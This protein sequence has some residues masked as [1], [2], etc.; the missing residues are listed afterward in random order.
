MIDQ[1][2][3]EIFQQNQNLTPE[4]LQ[5]PEVVKQIEAQ[6]QDK[7]DD[8]MTWREERELAGTRIL[9]YYTRKLD[10]KT[11]FNNGF[12]DALIAGEEIYCVDETN[13]EPVVRRCNPLMTYF[14]TN[15]HSHRVEDSNIIVEEQYLPLGE[16]LDRYHKYL[17]KAEIQELEDRN[18]NGGTR[19]SSKNNIINYGE[20]ISWKDSSDVDLFVGPNFNNASNDFNNYRVLRCVWRSIRLIKILHYLDENNEEQETEV[21]SSFKPDKSLGQWTEDMAIGEFWEG[22]KIANK[23]YVKVQPRSI[24]FRTLNNFSSCQSGY[25]GSIYNTNGQKVFSFMDKVKP[26]HLM[27]IT[28]AYRT[29]MAFMK[30]KGKIGL[31]D[32][33]LIPDGMNMDTWMYF[34]ETMGWAVIDSFKEGKKG[35]AMGKLAGMN[36]TRSDKIDLEMG[37]YIQQHIVAMQQIESRLEKI[38]GINDARKGTVPASAGLG[39]TQQQQQASYETTEP[40]FRVHD[41]IKLRVLAA[42]LETAK[43]CLKNGNKTFQYILSD[44]NTEIFTIDGEQFNEAEYGIVSSDATSDMENLAALK[45]ATEMSIQSGTIDG[46]EL[47]TVFS[48]NS[49]SSKV[50]KLRK[51]TKEK[52]KQQQANFE[53][54][55]KVKQED[56][57]ARVKHEQDLLDLEYYKL[58][59]EAIQNQLDRELDIQL[60]EIKAYAFDEGSNVTDISGAADSALKQAEINMKFVNEN[61]KLAHDHKQKEE[62]RLLKER[63]LKIKKEIEDKKIAAIDHQSK[64]QEKM[65]D[66][67]LKHDKEMADKEFKLEEK[68]MNQKMKLE[69][70]KAKAAIAKSRATAKKSKTSK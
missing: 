16:V 17:T 20:S 21:P 25:I 42:L 10:L 18:F 62:D 46:E 13:K 11:L 7:L 41:N 54:E 33:A 57:Q 5:D 29:E 1:T 67:Q 14:L 36:A 32:K 12:E 52:K 59:Q 3:I 9:E 56:I 44:L 27:Y 50:H 66:K 61:N 53:T 65:Q 31:L 49:Y 68:L 55:Q 43:Y 37:N 47:L 15:P 8:V 38:T 69:A 63:E 58:E 26:D 70:A 23:Y 64:N 22:T 6:L 60:E 4:Q 45:R 24:Q 48:N 39:V 2:V 35:A 51:I 30:S 40:Y 19:A 34:A 28:M